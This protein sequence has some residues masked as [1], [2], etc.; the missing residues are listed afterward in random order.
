M[1]LQKKEVR[2]LLITAEKHPVTLERGGREFTRL[3]KSFMLA[4][5]IVSAIFCIPTFSTHSDIVMKLCMFSVY[6][7]VMVVAYEI[8][9]L[10]YMFKCHQ[11]MKVIKQTYKEVERNE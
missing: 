5:L 9:A 6:I 1:A 7:L 10:N 3:F 2:K 8:Y 11:F 4:L